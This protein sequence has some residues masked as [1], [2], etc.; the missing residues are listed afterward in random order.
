MA[1]AMAADAQGVW[2]IPG[3]RRTATRRPGGVSVRPGHAATRIEWHPLGDG[4]PRVVA[5]PL[6]VRTIAV[7]ADAIWLTPGAV[8]GS[9]QY[10][11]IQAVPGGSWRV[12]RA[13]EGEIVE[14]VA[15]DRGLV[16]TRARAPGSERSILTC[17][18]SAG[19]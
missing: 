8:P 9:E 18:R 17:H 12:W 11:L 15:P 2:L 7:G 14:A 10:V 16:V 6:P 3:V 1:A 4:E 19:R 13:P 5:L